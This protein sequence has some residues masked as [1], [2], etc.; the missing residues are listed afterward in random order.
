MSNLLQDLRQ[1]IR[2]ALRNPGFTLVAVFTLAIGIAANTT[3][4]NWLDMMLLR[5]IPGATRPSQLVAFE[6]VAPDGKELATSWAD[7][8]DYR[9]RLHLVSGLMVSAPGVL[10]IGEGDH[11]ER[12]WMEAVSG[13][14]FEVLGV[15]PALG[16]VFSREE[17]GD[18]PG[19]F[20]V[21]VIGYNLW[22]RRFN[23]D[24][25]AIGSKLL[26]NG[27]PMTII[28]VAPPAFHG[29]LP[30]VFLEFWVPLTMDAQLGVHPAEELL[31]RNT[32]MMVA[33]ARLA[34]G[35]S[36]EQGRAECASIARRLAEENPRTNGSIGATLLPI[37]EGHFGG[38]RMMVG[39]LLILMAACGVILLIVCANVANLLLARATSRHKE[40]GL[41]LA[42]GASRTRLMRYLFIESLVLAVLGVLAGIPLAM[43]MNQSMS[44]LMPRGARIPV[45]FDIPLS[46]DILLFNL[47]VC[48][49]A[50]LASG[51]APALHATRAS[52]NEV[53]KEGGRSSSEGARSQ[54][55]RGVLVIAEVA[56]ALVAVVG[57]GLFAKSFQMAQRIEPGFDPHHVL[58]AH[59]DLSGTRYSNLERRLLFER[60]GRKVA[61]QPGVEGAS[62]ASVV[63]LWFTGNPN[64]DVQVEGYVRGQNESMKINLNAVSPGYFDVMRIPLIEGR[65]FSDHDTETSTPVMI[66]NQT[67]VRR[68]LGDGAVIGRHVSALRE[69]FTIVGVARDIKYIK[70]TEGATPYFYVP[71]RQ[72]F[73]GQ[74]LA[75]QVRTAEAPERVAAI[76]QRQVAA[77]DPALRVFDAMPMMESITAGLF[78]QRMA[79][80]LLAGL[81]IFALALA[82]TGLYS[83]MAYS[84]AQRTQE[85]GIRMALGAKPAD[86]LRMVVRGGMRLTLIGVA[87]GVI[88]ALALMRLAASLLVHVSASDPLVFIGAA[89]FLAAV[90]LA[91]SYLPALRATR[92][93]PNDALRCE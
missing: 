5:P 41:R 40:F 79:A 13:N 26:V 71:M 90:A 12:V 3:V 47:I 91:A 58:V 78:G 16:R 36:I 53:L 37:R 32:R 65:D 17:Y 68:F 44:Y 43:W 46:G 72:V 21:A 93:D 27:Q 35:A 55:L 28:G 62:W 6:E 73:D 85:I 70:P 67:F 80:A 25:K 42:M 22:Q 87:I 61:S 83:V 20:P 31:D 86:V 59:I 88:L 34:P 92:I 76:V 52:L 84:V 9:D 60:L 23:G 8:R 1:G 15:R 49:A 82:A 63:P 33:I 4:F 11:A 66:V 2:M 89:L 38:Q 10:N 56:M 81:G 18:K 50:C 69:T 51:I 19:A 74:M 48:V 77:V 14:A 30:G 64:A 29:S 57:A 75:L 7:F 39:P 24:P 45:S 54:R